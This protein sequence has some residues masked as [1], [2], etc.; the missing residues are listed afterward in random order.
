MPDVPWFKISV[1]N[2]AGIEKLFRGWLEAKDKNGVPIQ[3][4]VLA[5]EADE[6]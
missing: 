1:G 4:F 2:K 3:R 6:A 5:D